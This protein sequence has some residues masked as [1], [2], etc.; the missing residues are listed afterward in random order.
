MFIVFSGKDAPLNKKF[1]RA[2]T[3]V[4]RDYN[5]DQ[6]MWICG[7]LFEFSAGDG[8]E[9]LRGFDISP[10]SAKEMST[11]N[12]PLDKVFS[13]GKANNVFVVQ[14]VKGKQDD[15]LNM[16]NLEK[17]INSRMWMMPVV[18]PRDKNLVIPRLVR[19]VEVTEGPEKEKVLNAAEKN[20][21]TLPKV[22]EALIKMDQFAFTFS[23]QAQLATDLVTNPDFDANDDQ[24][25]AL[26]Q[27]KQNSKPRSYFRGSV[28]LLILA[29]FFLRS[30]ARVGIAKTFEGVLGTSWA[31]HIRD[32]S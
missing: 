4:W 15:S 7:S 30:C 20:I 19:S 18:E 23:M 28:P 8:W 9:N 11:S 5:D 12:N 17:S 6:H 22:Y 14:A 32:G 21:G 24:L 3:K 2:S 31:V 27:G 16:D 29:C 25:I 26:K 1:E 13:S 10:E